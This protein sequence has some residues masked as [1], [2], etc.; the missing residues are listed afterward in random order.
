MFEQ[1][2]ATALF[3]TIA[4]LLFLIRHLILNLGIK[5][6]RRHIFALANAAIQVIPADHK[7]RG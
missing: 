7:A 4:C 6:K 2:L 3:F 5:K 1:I